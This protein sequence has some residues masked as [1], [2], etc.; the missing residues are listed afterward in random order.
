MNFNDI[1][2]DINII[3]D[4][5]YHKIF[6]A[7]KVDNDYNEIREIIINNKKKLRDII[8]NKCVIINEALYHKDRL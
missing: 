4:F 3:D 8:F 7:N 1:E 6:E 2:F 5:F